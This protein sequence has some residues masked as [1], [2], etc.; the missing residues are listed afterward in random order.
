MAF[1]S[2]GF[3]PG[4][5]VWTKPDKRTLADSFANTY[6]DELKE[7]LAPLTQHGARIL[8]VDLNKFY[9]NLRK[10]LKADDAGK[11][12]CY[13]P[14]GS[15][16]SCPKNATA[17][18]KDE[19]HPTTAGFKVLAKQVAKAYQTQSTIPDFAT[20]ITDSGSLKGEIVN[21]GAIV[22]YQVQNSK[23]GATVT[24]SGTLIFVGPDKL[25][26]AGKVQPNPLTRVVKGPKSSDV[27][28][29]H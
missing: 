24:R 19:L 23:F 9:G 20:L 28:H 21:N 10:D 5:A 6:F 8:L 11:F 25:S 7:N 16:K 3:V 2:V 29:L 4:W 17:V 14:T 15:D 18:L 22:V 26:I 1:S 13:G 12:D 27:L